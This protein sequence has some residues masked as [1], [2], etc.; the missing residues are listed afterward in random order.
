MLRRRMPRSPAQLAAI[1]IT[2][3]L[4]G[5]GVFWLTCLV[6]P[7]SRATLN[8]GT[9][10]AQ[11]AVDPF[12]LLGKFPHRLLAP[13]VAHELGLGGDRYWL[14]AH[15][16]TVLLIAMIFAAAMLLGARWWQA[17]L[18]TTTIAFTGTVQLYKGHVGYP[19][20]IT[21][22][23]MTATIVARRHPRTFWTLQFLNVMHHEQILFFWPWLLWWRHRE[24]W[25]QGKAWLPDAFGAAVVLGIYVLWRSHV[26]AH[27]AQQMLTLEHYESLKYFPVGTLGLTA[28][29]LLST[30]IWFGALPVLVAWHAFVDGWRREGWG[31]LLFLI[32]LHAVFGVAHDVYRFSCFLFVPVLF[33][34]LRLC[35]ERFGAWLLA[36]LA[37]VSVFLIRWQAPVFERIGTAVLVE[38]TPNGPAV[39][40]E[41]VMSIVPEVIPANAG[42]FLAYGLVLVATILVGWLWARASRQ[43]L[44][45]QVLASGS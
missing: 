26:G 4:V 41:P 8:F 36:G 43:R 18:L 11:M 2:S 17:L 9:E 20:P 10:Y 1:W 44:A 45:G 21:W 24:D 31:I 25:R 34:G 23:L 22:L 14:F 3:L 32:S 16:C 15:G 40:S 5:I 42:T 39:R 30:F 27:A 35:R 19:D 38:M 28:L 12:A 33:A 37:L 6:E 29:N 13:L 7:A